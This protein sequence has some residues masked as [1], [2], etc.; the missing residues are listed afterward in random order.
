MQHRKIAILGSAPSLQEVPREGWEYWSLMSNYQY[1]ALP[2][3]PDRW[4][5]L[6]TIEHLRSVGV[7]E[8]SIQAAGEL[9]NLYMFDPVGKAKLFP[10]E[11]VLQL[12]EYYTS[13]IAW[14]MGL[15]IS[16][17]PHTI[18]LFGVDLILKKEYEK[19]RP[20]IEHWGGVARGMGIELEIAK[21]SPLFKGPLYCDPFAYEL[22]LRHED[23][24][25]KKRKAKEEYHYYR[26]VADV[27]KDLRFT[28]G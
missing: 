7:T 1:P 23:A 10:K 20:C 11:K 14:L 15:A 27:L 22:R 24:L 5:E 8:E 6:H 18:G 28:K 13:S 21:S 12:G 16:E 26:G 9:D 25:K 2:V 17:K 4:F 19:E 3:V